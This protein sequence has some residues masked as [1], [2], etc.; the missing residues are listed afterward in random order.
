MRLAENLDRHKISDE[1][2]FR[3]DWNIN[4]GVICPL[5]PKKKNK[6]KKNIFDLVWNIACL[7]L[8]ETL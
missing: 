5:V 2:E 3:S 4:F 8:N 6:K 1:F 7:V